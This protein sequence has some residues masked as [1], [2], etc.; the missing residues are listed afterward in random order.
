M[1]RAYPEEVIKESPNPPINVESLRD[2][3]KNEIKR[4]VYRLQ[5]SSSSSNDWVIYLLAFA[6]AL[7]IFAIILYLY[8]QSRR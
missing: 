8:Y 1:L 6:V 4:E 5:S 3:L 7:L 2:E